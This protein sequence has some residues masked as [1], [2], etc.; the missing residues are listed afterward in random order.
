MSLFLA[1]GTRPPFGFHWVSTT[2]MLASIANL[3]LYHF[4]RI[5]K[6][7]TSVT[8]SEYINRVRVNEAIRLLS[9]KTL[10]ITGRDSM[11]AITSVRFLKDI[12]ASLQE[13]IERILDYELT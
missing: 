2:G 4:C 9:D 6:K 12:Q 13:T 11:I 1:S 5:F 10:N 8:A 3:S 7:Y